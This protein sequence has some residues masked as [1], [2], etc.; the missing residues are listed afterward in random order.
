[1]TNLYGQRFDL[2]KSGKHTLVQIPKGAALHL[3]RVEAEAQREGGH[4]ADL[5]FT[6]LNITGRWTHRK[7]P[8]RFLATDAPLKRPKW[9]SLGRVRAKVVHG[10][11]LQGIRY[12]NFFVKNLEVAG[13]EVGGLLGKDDHKFAATPPSECRR[14]L[15]L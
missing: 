2:M 14:T 7:H 6:E 4:C 15:T 8:I 5:Y 11:T 3:L 12:L 10:R 13:K 9:M 1:M